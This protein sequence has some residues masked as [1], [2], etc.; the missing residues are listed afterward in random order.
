MLGSDLLK[1][2]TRCG[3][4]AYWATVVSVVPVILLVTVLVRIENGYVQGGPRNVLPLILV[5]IVLM[6][7]FCRDAP[8]AQGLSRCACLSRSDVAPIARCDLRPHGRTVC[9][10]SKQP[11]ACLVQSRVIT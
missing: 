8:S 3:S 9:V 10:L 7:G 4:A 1:E 6:A 11:S 5:L 2:R